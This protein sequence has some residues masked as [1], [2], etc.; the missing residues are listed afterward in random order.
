MSYDHRGG[1]RKCV[2]SRCMYMWCW[3]S[4]W[5][6]RVYRHE[7]EQILDEDLDLDGQNFGDARPRGNLGHTRLDPNSTENWY[8]DKRLII[9]FAD[10]DICSHS[11]SHR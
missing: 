4:N 9:I 10:N 5:S 2:G 7:P 6:S 8:V 1:D 3:C 11:C